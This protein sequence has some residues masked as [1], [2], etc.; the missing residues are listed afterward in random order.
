VSHLKCVDVRAL[1]HYHRVAVC[2]CEHQDRPKITLG[3]VGSRIVAVSIHIVD[4]PGDRGELNNPWTGQGSHASES[5]WTG[6]IRIHDLGRRLRDHDHDPDDEREDGDAVGGDGWAGK[7]DRD[8]G[9]G[10]KRG[11]DDR[12]DNRCVESRLSFNFERKFHAQM[13]W[14]RGKLCQ[15]S[16][17]VCWR[18]ALVREKGTRDSA[19]DESYGNGISMVLVC[20]QK[21]SGEKVSVSLVYALGLR[22]DHTKGAQNSLSCPGSK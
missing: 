14:Q 16:Q 8:R 4:V 2:Q 3:N 9:Q 13:L 20:G 18:R 11:D 10:A 5:Q 6:S 22:T 1:M 15:K 17:R 12:D 21:P 19:A 7:G